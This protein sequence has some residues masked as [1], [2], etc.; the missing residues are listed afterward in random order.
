MSYYSKELDD[1]CSCALVMDAA[2][3]YD[4]P[5]RT[6]YIRSP[7]DCELADLSEADKLIVQQVVL[8]W[9]DQS[10]DQH[11]KERRPGDMPVRVTISR[12]SYLF[13]GK[14]NLNMD[15]DSAVDQFIRFIDDV[16]HGTATTTFN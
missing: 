4:N 14:C 3:F 1:E 8:S 2:F 12:R 9:I 10:I 7:L 5:H 15:D 6:K 11:E 16:S 13:I